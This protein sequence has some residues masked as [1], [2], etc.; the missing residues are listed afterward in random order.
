LWVYDQRGYP[1]PT[2]GNFYLR[3]ARRYYEDAASLMLP[4]ADPRIELR[5]EGDGVYLQLNLDE[6]VRRAATKLV[7]TALLGKAKVPGLGYEN[8]DG[9]RLVIDS[10]YSGKKRNASRP[11][12]GPFEAAGQGALKVRVW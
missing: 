6:R 10:D 8:A 11:T 4:E 5:D 9:S 3:G 7:D 1:L 12:P 2:G